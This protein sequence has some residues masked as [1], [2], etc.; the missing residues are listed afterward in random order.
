MPGVLD[1]FHNFPQNFSSHFFACKK[2][3][4]LHTL[5]HKPLWT[6]PPPIFSFSPHKFFSTLAH[7][8]VPLVMVMELVVMVAIV[9]VIMLMVMMFMVMMMEVGG[10]GGG[11]G[12]HLV[13]HASP[14]T[15]PHAPR[16]LQ[17]RFPARRVF[18]KTQGNTFSPQFTLQH[19][20]LFLNL[21]L[22]ALSSNT[23]G[24]RLLHVSECIPMIHFFWETPQTT[25][26]RLARVSREG[27]F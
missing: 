21:Y 15:A 17:I 4:Y 26:Q 12:V 24:Q 5:Y 14:Q 3:L 19:V 1:S 13:L 8:C 11:G 25:C 22:C 16:S 10:G 27:L 20:Q 9:T 7:L 23:T 6:T 2:N 18:S